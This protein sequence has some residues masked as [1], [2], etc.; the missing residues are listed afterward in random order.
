MRPY[1]FRWDRLR[2]YLDANHLTIFEWHVLATLTYCAWSEEDLLKRS[3]ADS[4]LS[5]GN[6]LFVEPDR[7]PQESVESLLRKEYITII[8]PKS[9]NNIVDYLIKNPAYGPLYGLPSHNFVDLTVSGGA[10]WKT[11]EEAQ[12]DKEPPDY[13]SEYYDDYVMRFTWCGTSKQ[14]AL[15]E[16][17][18]KEDEEN[19]DPPRLFSVDGPRFIGKWRDRWWRPVMPRG[20]RIDALFR[21]DHH[22]EPSDPATAPC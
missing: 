9:I 11:L 4:Q 5:P 20:Y 13:H 22:G 16:L 18:E 10:V 19:G 17:K 3:F 15:R 14:R 8:T 6:P 1:H 12:G 21:V 2:A 7:D